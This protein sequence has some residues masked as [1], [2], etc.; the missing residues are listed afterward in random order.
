MIGCLLAQFRLLLMQQLANKEV[1]NNQKRPRK[2]LIP[3]NILSARHK[4]I[5]FQ[6]GTS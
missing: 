1:I 5:V 6:Q 4:N 2:L 3:T